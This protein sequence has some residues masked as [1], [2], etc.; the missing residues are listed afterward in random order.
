MTTPAPAPGITPVP[1]P[2]ITPAPEQDWR[3]LL[4]ENIRAEKSF[5]SIKGKDWTEAGP[6]LAGQYLEAQKYNVGALRMPKPDAPAEEWEKFYTKLGRP[7][8]A[9]KYEITKGTL[10]EGMG[11]DEEFFG[12]FRSAAHQAG[13]TSRQ[14]QQMTDWYTRQMWDTDKKNI[15]AAQE[16][17]KALE[18]EWGGAYKRN[19]ALSQRAAAEYGG[20]EMVDFLEKSGLGNNPV[21]VKFFARVGHELL[22]D[23]LIGEGGDMVGSEGAKAEIT[24]ILGDTKHPYFNRAHPE[25]EAAMKKMTGLYQVAYGT[26]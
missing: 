19:I 1:D 7:E 5:E 11:W 24:K 9:D 18:G 25:H 26:I 14:A 23:Q 12:G 13:L 10:P 4:P 3:T 17:L 21:M 20:P 2:G 15:G 6:K 8:A 16:T 22:E